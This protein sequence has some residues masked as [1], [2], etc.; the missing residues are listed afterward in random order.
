MY[1][2]CKKYYDVDTVHSI[3]QCICGKMLWDLD[4][5]SMTLI[6]VFVYMGIVGHCL[7]I[8]TNG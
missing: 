6:W 8:V 2:I 5:I 1:G 3:E 7:S 4:L